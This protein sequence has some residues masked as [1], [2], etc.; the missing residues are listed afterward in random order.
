MAPIIRTCKAFAAIA[1]LALG[2]SAHAAPDAGDLFWTAQRQEIT[3]HGDA[4]LKSY[5]RLLARSPDSET[6][7]NS[8]LAAAVREGS[9]ADALA[10]VKAAQRAGQADSDAPLMLFADAFRRRKWPD[11]ERALADLDVAG[12]FSFMLPMLR[13]WLNVAQNRDSG[14]SAQS[15]QTSGLAAFYS[16]DQLVYFDLADRNMV[17]AKLRLRNFRGYNESYGRFLAGHAMGEFSRAGDAEFASALGQQIGLDAGNYAVP[18]MTAELGLAMLFARLGLAL[19]EQRQAPKGLYFVRIASW[20]APSSDAAKLALAELLERQDQKEKAS[21]LLKSIAPAS[22]FW[23]PAV[24]N[25]TEL[26]ATADEA[27]AIARAASEGQ[28]ASSQLKLLHAQ[29]LEKAGRSDLAVGVYRGLL[30]QDKAGVQAARRALYLLLLA[31]ALDANGDWDGARLALE[32]AVQIDAQNPQI[33]NYLGYS[34]LERRIDVARGFDLVAQAHQIAPQSAA[35]TDSLGWAHFLKG[36]VESAI[37]LLERAV[38]G[39]IADPAINEHLG[40][41]YWAAGRRNEARFAWK[42]AALSAEGKAGERLAQKI[43][44]GWA[45]E[46]AAP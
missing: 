30:D 20:I 31:S 37:P 10:A 9:F 15:L 3:G 8:L 26:A 24:A 36:D 39:A 1:W 25:L 21:A 41:A 38:K 42:A 6:A 7:A 33:L 18:R 29:M 45:K 28:P 5:A 40:D 13:G 11:A 27:A 17:Q 12:D 23:F 35:I 43:D 16:D 32:D 14:V 22:P 19:D 46:A 4:A 34:L 2:A 44:F